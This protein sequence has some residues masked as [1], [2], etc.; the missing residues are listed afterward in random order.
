MGRK[1]FIAV[2]CLMLGL[3][4]LSCL[5]GRPCSRWLPVKTMYFYYLF[6]FTFD[7]VQ[8]F[9]HLVLYIIWM[10]QAF[11]WFLITN[12]FAVCRWSKMGV[13]HVCV[14]SSC[15]WSQGLNP[16]VELNA[17]WTGPTSGPCLRHKAVRVHKRVHA[18]SY[19]YKGYDSFI[20]LPAWRM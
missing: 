15:R 8:C 13:F 2:V 5:P 14:S 17:E 9:N 1:V 20:F 11:I 10:W 16:D 12:N 19:I 7:I 4:L 3:Y 6:F 18:S